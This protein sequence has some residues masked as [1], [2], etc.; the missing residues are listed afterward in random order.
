MDEKIDPIYL[1]FTPAQV[2]ECLPKSSE[3]AEYLRYYTESARRFQRHRKD[4]AT[5]ISAMTPEA[6]KLA[7]K[8]EKQNRQIEKDERFWSATCLM[9]FHFG[10]ETPQKNWAALIR[11]CFGYKP[12]HSIELRSW[13]EC[14]EGKL[15]LVFEESLPSPEEYKRW[16]KTNLE[17][18]QRRHFIR[19]S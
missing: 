10:K 7:Q 5:V 2:S 11:K 8:L 17:G 16:L 6:L 19:M 12:P 13:E 9:S 3:T 1:P 15:H 4:G 18:S 14:F